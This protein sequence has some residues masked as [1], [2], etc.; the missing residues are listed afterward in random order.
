M[1]PIEERQSRG[2][3][4]LGRRTFPETFPVNFSFEIPQSL[5]SHYHSVPLSNWP[6]CKK[7][8]GNRRFTVDRIKQS[9]S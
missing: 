7:L 1:Q 3:E 2:L 8:I 5:A 6:R 4:S 9:T